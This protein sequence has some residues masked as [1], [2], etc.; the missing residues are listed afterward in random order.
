MKKQTKTTNPS[1]SNLSQNKAPWWNRPL[2]GEGGLLAELLS[3]FRKPEVSEAT[4][5]LHNREIMDARL[6]ANT[7]KV[8]DTEKFGSLEF[9]LLLKLRYLLL[10]GSE[11]QRKL[12]KSI[13][14]LKVAIAAKASFIAL[15]QT[16]LSYRSSKQQEFYN[17]VEEQLKKNQE[18]K[19]YFR[20]KIDEKLT[21]FIPIIKTQEGKLAL[22][23][24][25]NH[26][27]NISEHPLGLKLLSRFKTYQFN[28]YS[29]LKKIADIIDILGKK[30]L[31]DFKSI[32]SVVM[33]N[34]DVFEQLSQIINIEKMSQNPDTYATIIQYV[35]L[36]QKHELSFPKF[37]ELIKVIGR[38]YSPY[39]AILG[40]RQAHPPSEYRQPQEFQ[41]SIPGEEIYLKYKKWLTDPNTGRSYIDFPAEQ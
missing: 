37:E 22:H 3:K 31:Q 41:Q 7:A 21:E 34:Y 25:G 6:L 20:Q 15:D 28:D 13:E 19:I 9:L 8:I 30:D 24:Y 18:D 40:I 29:I 16:E 26:L 39:Q 4:L 27:N 17:F 36:N 12:H 5:S 11:D 2:F 32:I 38:W 33:V 35:A 14:L 1:V 23:S 10:G